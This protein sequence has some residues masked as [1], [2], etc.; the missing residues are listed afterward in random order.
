MTERQ[1][2]LVFDALE[3]DERRRRADFIED[4]VV[5]VWGGDAAEA[6]VSALRAPV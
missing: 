2:N 4:V 1:L 6:R 5:A 3:R